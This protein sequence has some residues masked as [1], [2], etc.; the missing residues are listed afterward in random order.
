MFRTRT[1]T[2]LGGTAALALS[3][4][5]LAAYGSGGSAAAAA[6]PAK[7]VAARHA[8]TIRV[9][10]SS[11]LGKFLVDSSGRTLYLFQ[12]D[13]RN[14]SACFGACAAIWPPLRSA[15]A[16][17][18]AGL[19]RAKVTTIKRS[20]G[21]PQVAYAGHPLYLYVTDQKPGDTTGQ[22]SDNFGAKWF[23]LSPAGNK[24][25]AASSSA[26]GGWSGSGH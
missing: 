16:V 17:V 13:A 15:K 18:G 14:K 22:G 11:R 23:V 9:A 1:L 19:S 8:A 5:A 20:D 21:Q 26:G 7:T 12:K 24:I 2:Y 25:T 3:G 4:A 6:T 10:T